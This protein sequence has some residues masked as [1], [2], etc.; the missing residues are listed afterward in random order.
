MEI[1]KEAEIHEIKIDVKN[2]TR[3]RA[4]KK[5]NQAKWVQKADTS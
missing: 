2:L 3:K 5:Q 1:N 4:N